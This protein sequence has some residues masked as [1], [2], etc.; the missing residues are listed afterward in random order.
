[1]GFKDRVLLSGFQGHSMVIKDSVVN[2]FHGHLVVFKDSVLLSG[3]QGYSM[4]F[5]ECCQ[6]ISWTLGGLKRVFY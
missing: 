3:F 4:V 5:K 1:M 6:C 2:G